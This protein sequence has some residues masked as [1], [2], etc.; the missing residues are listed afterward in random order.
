MLEK[1]TGC[2]T[3][4][5]KTITGSLLATSLTAAT[6]MTLPAASAAPTFL[7]STNVSHSGLLPTSA[8]SVVSEKGTAVASWL[9]SVDGVARVQ[10]SFFTGGPNGS[11]TFPETLTDSGDQVSDPNVAMNDA[12]EAVITWLERDLSDDLRVAVSRYVGSGDFDGVQ[13]ISVDNGT[14][15]TAGY[16]VAMDGTGK[17]FAAHRDTDGGTVNRIRVSTLDAEGTNTSTT[18]SD[19]SSFAPDIAVDTAGDAIVAWYDAGDGES[20]VRVRRLD[21]GATT[22]DPSDTTAAA[23]TYGVGVETALSDN[24]SGT[25][26]FT[27]LDGDGDYRVWASKSN[28]DGFLGSASI[29]SPDDRNASNLSL[30]QNDAGTAF[31][32][33]NEAGEGSYV[34]FA[35]RPLTNGWTTAGKVNLALSKA[36]SPRAAISDS[37]M[38]FISWTDAGHLQAAYR[39]NPVLVLK[40]FDS[41]AQ[42]FVDGSALAGVDKQ[43]NALIGGTMKSGDQG[44]VQ[45]AFLDAAGPTSAITAPTAGTTLATGFDVQRSAK[46]RFSAIGTGSIRVRTAV[47]N[48]GFGATS[49]PSLNQST[50]KISYDGNAGRTY[51]F[52]AQAKDAVNNTGAWSAEKCTTTPVDDASLIATKGFSHTEAGGHYQGTYTRATKKGATLRLKDVKADKVAILVGKTANGGTIDVFFGGEKLGR[53]SL[54]GSG[55]KHLIAW[56][57]LGGL[58]TGDLVIKVV[59]ENGKTIRIDGVVAL[60]KG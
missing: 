16:S 13:F 41:G 6:L 12:G 9:R 33:W 23:G 7:A 48:A 31:A 26:A 47:W 55:N 60:K 38:T 19:T 40:T 5:R 35:S 11:W 58:K 44:S 22:W 14:S 53:Y 18:L 46:D 17:V 25:V 28:A 15:A 42:G 3:V 4:F 20:Q 51:C 8:K 50:Q 27:R 32:A 52:A 43:G 39:T 21:A 24:G 56:K 10:A 30:S 1:T 29:V 59:S 49:Y 54:K 34:G 57:D 45:A 37:G 36:T 2:T